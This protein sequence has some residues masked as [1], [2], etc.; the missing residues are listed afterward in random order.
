[1][2]QVALNH[3]SSAACNIPGGRTIH[4]TFSLP[5]RVKTSDKL[6]VVSEEQRATLKSAMEGKAFL[7][8]DEVSM[9]GPV[10]L[11]MMHERLVQPLECQLPFGEMSL[12]A[13]GDFYQ[14]QP[15][16]PPALYTSLID[17]VTGTREVGRPEYKQVGTDLFSRFKLF[18][19]K[20][21]MSARADREHGSWVEAFSSGNMKPVD[22][23]FI[24]LFRS[25]QLSPTDVQHCRS[26]A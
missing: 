6:P 21:Q 7:L 11:G 24:E 13:L 17:I 4:S 20:T 10:L 2:P 23:A 5:I 14:L 18:E 19:L 22:R 8:I 12:I 3:F 25:R 1:M 16:A 9:V 15:C 26:W